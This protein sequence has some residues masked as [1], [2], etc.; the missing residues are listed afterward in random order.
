MNFSD[1][2]KGD[3]EERLKMVGQALAATESSLSLSSAQE[4]DYPLIYVSSK[5]LELTGYE[6]SEVIGR[7][8]RFLQGEDR[9]QPGLEAIRRAL[10]EGESVRVVLRN[11]T[12]VG[13]RFYNELS[14]TPIFGVDKRVE[15]FLGIQSDVTSRV[16][17]DRDV[18]EALEAT[19]RQG[20]WIADEIMRRLSNT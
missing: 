3:L 7:N 13:K 2:L 11:Y 12:K 9:D 1:S 4:T 10:R 20:D 15:Y 14:I 18:E 6:R 5:F 16:L 19:F 8:C 17:R